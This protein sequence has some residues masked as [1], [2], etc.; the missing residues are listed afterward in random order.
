MIR[1]VEI[2]EHLCSD[3]DGH[4]Q[5]R[6]HGGMVAR[7][8][9]R[10][11][12][13]GHLGQANRTRFGDQCAEEASA[14]GQMPDRRRV[15]V[16]HPDVDELLQRIMLGIDH[17]HRPVLCIDQLDRGLDDAAEHV[18]QI[19]LLHDGL[20]GAQQRAQ[21]TLRLHDPC[22]LRN[23]GADRVFQISAG[24]IRK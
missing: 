3:S 10:A 21:A 23:Q 2:S 22:A 1:Q 20:I 6:V 14:L 4:A 18:R 9:D 17:A 12:I 15:L 7:E 11:R 8:A 5:E 13:V 19:A 16:R 24:S